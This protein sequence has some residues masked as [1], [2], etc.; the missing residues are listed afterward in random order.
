ME[1]EWLETERLETEWLET[2]RS[3]DA[4]RGPG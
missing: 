1:T 2:A 3:V 4:D